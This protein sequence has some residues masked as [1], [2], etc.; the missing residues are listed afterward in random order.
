MCPLTARRREAVSP[1]WPNASRIAV[2]GAGWE[3]TP[4]ARGWGHSGVTLGV[5][6]TP[7][8]TIPTIQGPEDGI[9]ASDRSSDLESHVRIMPG[10]PGSPVDSAACADLSL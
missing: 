8:V 7:S 1:T 3:P 2:L 10:A 9:K 4:A 5:Q 6:R